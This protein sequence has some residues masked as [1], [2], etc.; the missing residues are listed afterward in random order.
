MPC[1]RGVKRGAA[2][3]HKKEKESST[4][5]NLIP[6]LLSTHPHHPPYVHEPLPTFKY[7]LSYYTQLTQLMQLMQLMQ[8]TQ[9][10]QPHYA[11]TQLKQLL[12]AFC[13]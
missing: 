3:K 5:M 2:K 9:L 7:P 11:I 12:F 4:R 13:I 8:L 10:T 6:P 1:V